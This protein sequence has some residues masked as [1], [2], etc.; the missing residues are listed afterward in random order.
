GQYAYQGPIKNAGGTIIARSD[1]S[2]YADAS[3][4]YVLTESAHVYT[5]ASDCHSWVSDKSY[6][7]VNGDSGGSESPTVFKAGNTYYWIG[8]Y[9]NGRGA[10]KKLYPTPPR[11]RR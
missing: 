10:Q 11:M 6:A 4:A 5:L 2:A 7:A 9:K 3:G 8:S 1:M